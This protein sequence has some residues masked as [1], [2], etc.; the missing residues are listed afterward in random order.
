MFCVGRCKAS[1]AATWL[2]RRVLSTDDTTQAVKATRRQISVSLVFIVKKS[3]AS[4]SS[5]P[6]M[7]L[8]VLI[9]SVRL[10]I[11]KQAVQV[12]G[13][14]TVL[15]APVPKVWYQSCCSS[16]C[17]FQLGNINFKIRPSDAVRVV[18]ESASHQ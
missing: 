15:I 8:N 11:V 7:I 16:L 17:I 1:H 12:Q 4:R 13:Y 18:N 2:L 3:L 14:Q 10:L 5:M 9:I 6:F